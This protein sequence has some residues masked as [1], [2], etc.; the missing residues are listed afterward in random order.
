[1]QK[2]ELVRIFFSSFVITLIVFNFTLGLIWVDFKADRNGFGGFLPSLRLERVEPLVYSLDTPAKQ[3]RLDFTPADRFADV[4]RQAEIWALP[5]DWRVFT[6]TSLYIKQ[7]LK[8]HQ[9]QR[10][11]REFYKNAGLV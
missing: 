1:M 10:L 9:K 6:Q 3:Y 7:R 8:T 4:L 5:E 11:E 2:K